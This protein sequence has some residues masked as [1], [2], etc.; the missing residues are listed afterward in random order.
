MNQKLK[1]QNT[2]RRSDWRLIFT[3]NK[4]WKTSHARKR[5]PIITP[6]RHGLSQRG[7]LEPNLIFCFFLVLKYKVLTQNMK[8]AVSQ[9]N[10]CAGNQIVSN[11]LTTSNKITLLPKIAL[12]DHVCNRMMWLCKRLTK[13]VSS[14][15]L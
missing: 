2:W 15:S 14:H 13:L 10:A 9:L 5:I 12:R 7:K 6:Q 11:L 4:N 1:Q 8:Y 3:N